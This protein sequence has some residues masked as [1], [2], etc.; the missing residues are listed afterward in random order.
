MN[1]LIIAII[2]VVVLLIIGSVIGGTLYITKRTEGYCSEDLENNT[3]AKITNAFT[4]SIPGETEFTAPTFSQIYATN[5]A[6]MNVVRQR[7]LSRENMESGPTDRD[8]ALKSSIDEIQQGI[9]SRYKKKFADELAYRTEVQA[10]ATA[11]REKAMAEWRA[12]QER[13]AEEA[14]KA[15]EAR[16]AEQE[17]LAE[18]RRLWELGAEDRIL[19]EIAEQERLAEEQRQREI[20]A[21]LD[22]EAEMAR[23]AEEQRLWEEQQ[24]VEQAK[25]DYDTCK[26]SKCFYYGPWYWVAGTSKVIPAPAPGYR[27][28]LWPSEVSEGRI[29]IPSQIPASKIRFSSFGGNIPDQFIIRNVGGDGGKWASGEFV[30]GSSIP[31]N[32][33]FDIG[34]VNNTGKNQEGKMNMSWI[35][36]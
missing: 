35:L 1:G 5:E 16:I 4:S 15:Q 22:Y 20:Q 25:R 6:N 12:E 33:G 13:L 3:S 34:Q 11:A 8:A 9:Y 36:Y 28:T 29:P 26:S 32:D 21:R 19:A 18:E 2:V 14:R 10:A 31:Y 7:I 30:H 23:W 24:K 27:S 17:R